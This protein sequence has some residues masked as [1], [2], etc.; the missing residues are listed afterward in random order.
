[1]CDDLV[2]RRATAPLIYPTPTT[3]CRVYRTRYHST[4][5]MF[6]SLC[7]HCASICRCG[8]CMSHACLM[9]ISNAV[10]KNGCTAV[11]HPVPSYASQEAST[12]H[13]TPPLPSAGV[14]LTERHPRPAIQNLTT[15]SL[16]VLL[17]PY[18]SHRKAF[19]HFHI[20]YPILSFLNG[21]AMPGLILPTLDAPRFGVHR[22]GL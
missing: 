3:G 22:H 21:R 5:S 6:L 15:F 17:H 2:P 16:N 20:V 1:M 18:P 11:A 4:F 7:T 14:C 8:A 19:F 13:P 9:N 12:Y 10:H